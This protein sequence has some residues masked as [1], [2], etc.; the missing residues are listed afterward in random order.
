MTSSSL[1]LQKT[2]FTLPPSSGGD[3]SSDSS[4]DLDDV[5]I[6]MTS[7]QVDSDEKSSGNSPLL[8]TSQRL[9]IETAVKESEMMTS[10]AS[11]RNDPIQFRLVAI[12]TN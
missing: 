3:L 9:L 12:V 7:L 11:R 6:E 4:E 1:F 5:A 10:S 2:A 8:M